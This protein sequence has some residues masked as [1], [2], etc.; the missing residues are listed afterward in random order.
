MT[1]LS[2]YS[3]SGRETKRYPVS[4]EHNTRHMN[5]LRMIL[6]EML[7]VLASSGF[8]ARELVFAE[9][10]GARYVELLESDLGFRIPQSFKQ[11]S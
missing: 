11:R 4:S 2:E 5:A 1:I 6:S 10:A 7:E 8:D 9:P 3:S